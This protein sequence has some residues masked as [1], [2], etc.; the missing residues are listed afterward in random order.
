MKRQWEDEECNQNV[1]ESELL[2][3][4]YSFKDSRIPYGYQDCFDPRKHSYTFK[5]WG[6]EK[7]LLSRF[8]A[9]DLRRRDDDHVVQIRN[10]IP[11]EVFMKDI[12][13]EAFYVILLKAEVF[14]PPYE[15]FPLN[16]FQFSLFRELFVA[17]TT[18]RIHEEYIKCY[19]HYAN[20]YKETEVFKV[21]CFIDPK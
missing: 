7:M 20:R 15:N 18:D 6:F 17:R 19:N 2:L 21:Y 9:W 10:R 3:E 14:P 8:G 11:Q 4:T 1:S 13:N 5:L 12:M 16:Q